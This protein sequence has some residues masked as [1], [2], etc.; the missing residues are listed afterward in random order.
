LFIHQG[1]AAHR[2][3]EIHNGLSTARQN[4]Q[5]ECNRLVQDE[6][7][8]YPQ[9]GVPSTCFMPSVGSNDAHLLD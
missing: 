9:G 4:W 1:L 6:S 8:T 5:A 7:S 3:A 2:L